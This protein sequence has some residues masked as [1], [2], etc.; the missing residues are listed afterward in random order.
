MRWGILL[1]GAADPV[2]AGC[3]I[4]DREAGEVATMSRESLG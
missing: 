3:S 2:L 4:F 1:G